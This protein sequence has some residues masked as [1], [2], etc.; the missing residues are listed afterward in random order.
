MFMKDPASLLETL[1]REGKEQTWLEFKQNQ[2]EPERIGM[3]VSA[4]A[5]SAMS[6]GR[7]RGFLV[8]GIEDVTLREVGTTVRLKKKKIGGEGLQN[9]LSRLIEPS[10]VIEICDFDIHGKHFSIICV[11]PSYI[12]PVSFKGVQ[13]IRIGEHLKNLK[14]LPEHA[15]KL[16]LA[17]SKRRFEH[18]IAKAGVPTEEI[19]N[20]LDVATYYELSGIQQPTDNSE[21]L[22]AFQKLGFIQSDMQGQY[23][24][25]NLGAVLFGF[26]L[27]EFSGLEF[28]PIRLLMY[29][30]NDK[31]ASSD[32]FAGT[33]GYAIAF[34]S[35]IRYIMARIP[36][37]EFY[38]DG[39][40]KSLPRF[41][42]VAIRELT[43]NALIHQNFTTNGSGPV[44][45]VYNDR[46]EI[47]N[48]GNSL[49]ETDRMLDE[50]RSRNE[51]LA[52][53][54]R[55]LGICEERGGGLDKALA[56]I[57]KRGLP[58]FQF[59]PSKESMRVTIFGP[60]DF[61][62]MSKD[63]KVRSA[64]YHS[65]LCWIRH[66]NMNNTS[67]RRRFGLEDGEYQAVSS[68]ISEAKKRG[69][70]KPADENQGNKFA[71][72]VPYWA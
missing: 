1:L 17:T 60:K 68:V 45:E 12:S 5:N 66:D 52:A 18:A 16:W 43:A 49:I 54:M 56:E 51:H 36:K 21:M 55:D 4:L 44:I 29:D 9:W 20:L 8:F 19:F 65:V 27:T 64:F 11:E 46:I 47:I 31:T 71:R 30:G 28:K 32:E 48:P 67:L 69:R 10:L 38:V 15:R 62:E 63:E 53:R 34:A 37:S 39:I 40:R 59:N 3:Y 58:A 2:D 57:E 33:K 14:D 72:Y 26:D 22:R 61:K 70:I 7:D 6:E 35:F 13:Y 42:E 25:T 50:R 24:I 41:P 23:D